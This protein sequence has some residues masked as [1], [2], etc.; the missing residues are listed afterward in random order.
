MAGVLVAGAVPAQA[1]GVSLGKGTLTSWTGGPASGATVTAYAWPRG[2]AR[3]K[4]L[5]QI[6]TATTAADGTYELIAPDDLAR[7]GDDGWVDLLIEAE[8]GRMATI[9]MAS[10]QIG[11]AAPALPGLEADV[12]LTPVT[13]ASASGNK[14]S[15]GATQGKPITK[16]IDSTRAPTPIGELNNAYKDTTA[17][18]KFTEGAETTVETLYS[19]KA[20]GRFGSFGANGS[21]TLTEKTKRARSWTHKGRTQKLIT[22]SV[23]Y[24]L[25]ETRTCGIHGGKTWRTIVPKEGTQKGLGLHKQTGGLHQCN[26]SESYPGGGGFSTSSTTTQSRARSY[27]FEILGFGVTTHAQSGWSTEIETSYAFG[28]KPSKRHYICGTNNAP[29]DAA[30]RIFSGRVKRTRSA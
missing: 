17:S 4:T 29:A 8:D 19:A 1:S 10:R 26:G 16:H 6:A 13:R 24:D 25:N 21:K 18:F 2:R 12:P 7:F 30:D 15:N 9:G 14:C 28:G 27:G 23:R 11:A 5:H 20:D 22:M 3:T